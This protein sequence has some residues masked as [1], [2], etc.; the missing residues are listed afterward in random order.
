L[1]GLTSGWLKKNGMLSYGKDS[2]MQLIVQ[3]SQPYMA[4]S[5]LLSQHEQTLARHYVIG[6]SFTPDGKGILWFRYR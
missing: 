5:I 1:R 4:D 6:Y 2:R 3:N